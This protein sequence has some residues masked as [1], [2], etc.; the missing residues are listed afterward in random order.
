MFEIKFECVK[1]GILIFG[2]FQVGA[3]FEFESTSFLGARQAVKVINP[4]EW[5]HRQSRG[6]NP[7]P[8]KCA[9]SQARKRIDPNPGKRNPVGENLV[10]FRLILVFVDFF[11]IYVR[12]SCPLEEKSP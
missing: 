12:E 2:G 9:L 8:S 11:L 1:L 10:E 7:R 3:D 6:T 5:I 4:P